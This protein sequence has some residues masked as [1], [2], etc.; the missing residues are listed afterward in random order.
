L[1]ANSEQVATTKTGDQLLKPKNHFGPSYYGNPD[2]VSVDFNEVMKIIAKIGINSN[3]TPGIAINFCQNISGYYTLLGKK[4]HKDAKSLRKQIINDAL[5]NLDH[6]N[7][8]QH[9]AL[10]SFIGSDTHRKAQ[11]ARRASKSKPMI[12]RLN[13]A[14]ANKDVDLENAIIISSCYIEY[15]DTFRNIVNKDLIS[16]YNKKIKQVAKRHAL[17]AIM[18]GYSFIRA[19]SVKRVYIDSI[20]ITTLEIVVQE[21]KRNDISELDITDIIRLCPDKIIRVTL[22]SINRDRDIQKITTSIDPYEIAVIATRHSND[23]AFLDIATRQIQELELTGVW[24][25]KP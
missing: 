2:I 22:A 23:P 17:K 8:E 21:L 3:N 6:F 18:L 4:Q 16:A 13:R 9:L 7:T 20:R 24:K 1:Y 12:E 19:A 5:R 25:N 14:I 15:G 11:F 10:Q